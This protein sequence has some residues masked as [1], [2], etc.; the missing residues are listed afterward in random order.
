MASL[1]IEMHNGEAFM[2]LVLCQ[3]KLLT[4]VI[5]TENYT[6]ELYVV[7]GIEPGPFTCKESILPTMLSLWT[8]LAHFCTELM[9]SK[10]GLGESPS[11]T[12]F[13]ESP[14]PAFPS[15]KHPYSNPG[16]LW[17]LL[18]PGYNPFHDCSLSDSPFV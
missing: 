6:S 4:K 13:I 17:L 1:L 16:P 10:T 7:L 11:L 15:P 14:S 9:Q 2:S 18:W 8:T 12:Q 3:C 5:S